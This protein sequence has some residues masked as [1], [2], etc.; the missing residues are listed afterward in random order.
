MIIPSNHKEYQF[1][2]NIHDR[3]YIIDL[4]GKGNIISSNKT[5]MGYILT[6]NKNSDINKLLKLYKHTVN[7][8]DYK[9]I[10]D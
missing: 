10:I 5:N 9:I 6:I 4:I 2:Y 8:N 7:K 1:P 3:T